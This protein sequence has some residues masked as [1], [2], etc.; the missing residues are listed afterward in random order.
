MCYMYVEE[1]DG[2]DN[3]LITLAIARWANVS[4]VI[5]KRVLVLNKYAILENFPLNN[6]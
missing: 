3:L 5:I 1:Y 6:I 2:K 4:L